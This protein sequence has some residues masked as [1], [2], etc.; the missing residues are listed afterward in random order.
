M[1]RSWQ[2][3]ICIRIQNYNGSSRQSLSKFSCFSDGIPN[4]FRSKF[5]SHL[6]NS[7]QKNTISDL[8]F[9]IF[10]VLFIF[11][12]QNFSVESRIL[13]QKQLNYAFWRWIDSDTYH[14]NFKDITEKVQAQI[15]TTDTQWSPFSLK[16][17]TFGLGRRV[18][19]I[20][21]GAFGVFWDKISAPILVLWVPCPCFPLLNQ[22]VSLDSQGG[23]TCCFDLL[24]FSQTL[25]N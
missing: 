6:Q 14:Y 7:D 13:F 25:T 24:V 3:A 10:V 23:N 21:S 20:N 4:E 8:L 16:S 5:C 19:Q 2:I 11:S 17:R 22:G 12:G 15:R 1:C 9:Y 18:G